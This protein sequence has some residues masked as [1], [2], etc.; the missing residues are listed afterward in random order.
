[1]SFKP[2]VNGLMTDGRMLLPEQRCGVCSIEYS[3]LRGDFDFLGAPL[4]TT[5]LN[6]CK[7]AKIDIFDE[8]EVHPILFF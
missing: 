5:C 3:T 4:N 8:R 2:I 1:M 7:L 6:D